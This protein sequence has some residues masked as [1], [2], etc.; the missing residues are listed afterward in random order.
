M[1]V[2][3]GEGRTVF[4]FLL[5]FIIYYFYNLPH[6]PQTPNC[7]YYFHLKEESETYNS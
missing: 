5:F 2:D 1:S 6:L 3:A 7:G 4:L